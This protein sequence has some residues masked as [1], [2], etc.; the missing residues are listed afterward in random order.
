MK[1]EQIKKILAHFKGKL[2]NNTILKEHCNLNHFDFIS[3]DQYEDYVFQQEH[4]ER[5][6]QAL[7]SIFAELSQFKYI[8]TFLS[9]D[10]KR[11]LNEANEDIEWKIAKVLEDNGILYREIDLVTKNLGN[12]FQ[13]IME[14]AGRRANNMCAVVLSTLAKE[15]F[16]DSLILKHLADYYRSKAKELGVKLHRTQED[17]IVGE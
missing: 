8:P 6:A 2:V 3:E 15:K 5:T 1:P 10:E 7:A 4:D 11:T 17:V 16:G 9:E 13:A 14:N 12:A